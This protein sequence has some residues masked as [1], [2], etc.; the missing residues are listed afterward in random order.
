MNTAIGAAQGLTL[1]NTTTFSAVTTT[2]IDNVF[3]STY[4]NYRIILNL[5]SLGTSANVLFRL[6]T[7]GS[8]NTTSNY[9]WT[10]AYYLTSNAFY[11][12]RTTGASNAQIFYTVG[13]DKEQ[14]AIDMYAPNL[15]ATTSAS[16]TGVHGP[17]DINWMGS[18]GHNSTTQFDGFTIYTSTGNITGTIK[19]YGYK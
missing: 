13:Q 1:I 9:N 7:S 16:I 5:T 12:S 14:A 2:S 8:D 3:S 10:A 4:S 15:S 19:V 17:G 6:R 18:M 11:S